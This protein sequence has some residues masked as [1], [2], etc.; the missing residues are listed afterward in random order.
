VLKGG[1]TRETTLC[2]TVLQKKGAGPESRRVLLTSSAESYESK[3]HIKEGG[4]LVEI[5]PYLRARG[6]DE[7]GKPIYFEQHRD[8]TETRYDHHARTEHHAEQRALKFANTNGYDILAMAPTSGC[9]KGCQE[10]LGTELAKVPDNRRSE[11]ALRQY[12]REQ[13]KRNQ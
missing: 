2:I 5:G 11:E 9:C 4:K 10:A 13:R 7:K 12:H 8:G 6:K 3:L 1:R